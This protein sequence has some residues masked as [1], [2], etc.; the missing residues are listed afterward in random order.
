MAKRN[1]GERAAAAGAATP[2]P[3]SAKTTAAR[4]TNLFVTAT[5]PNA[6]KT[7]ITLGLTKA[8]VKAGRNVGFIKPVGSADLE[9]G[10]HKIDE[11]TLLV[12]RACNVH[13]NIDDMN[14]VSIRSG[15]PTEF[16]AKGAHEGLVK[17]LNGAFGRV[18]EGKEFVVVEGTGHGAVGASFG[19]SN[20]FTAKMLNAKVILISSGGIGHP[21]DEIL[22]NQRYFAQEGVEILGVIIN[23]VFPHEAEAIDG[24]A[25]RILEDHGLRLLGAIPYA[26]ELYQPSMMQVLEE[27]RG[28]LIN[29]DQ[30]LTHS[31][32]RILLGAMTP[33]NALD[34]MS[35]SQCIV[36]PGDRED[37]ILCALARH[38]LDPTREFVLTGLVLTGGLYPGKSTLDMIRRTDIPVIVAKEDSY[39]VASRLT[40]IVVKISPWDKA[41]VETICALVAEHVKISDVLQGLSR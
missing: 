36:T 10:K 1:K 14:P 20:A 31:L 7:A 18:S 19:L 30:S 8:F 3:E 24:I 17:K 22:L 33:H 34:R 2:A 4:T 39:T 11:D 35:G 27:L 6:G 32:G 25:R 26:E 29:G 21:I 13:C 15:F 38:V 28:N 12:S 5:R 41:K 16:T 37:L 40:Q 9:S 23:K